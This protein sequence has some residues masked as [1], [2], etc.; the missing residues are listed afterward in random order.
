MEHHRFSEGKVAQRESK[1]IFWS[2]PPIR[3]GHTSDIRSARR[4]TESELRKV[5]NKKSKIFLP[6]GDRFN[7][8]GELRCL[9]AELLQPQKKRKKNG[10]N[11]GETVGTKGPLISPEIESSPNN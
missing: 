1:Q 3:C 2:Q 11:L 6:T 10:E 7:T 5:K 8:D 9:S 4:R